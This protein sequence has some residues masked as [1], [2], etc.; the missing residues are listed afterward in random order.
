MRV[1]Q[2]LHSSCAEPFVVAALIA[3]LLATPLSVGLQGLDA[4]DLPLREIVRGAVWET[5]LDTA[6][7]LTA[8]AAAFALFAALFTFAA[9]SPGVARALSLMALIGAGLALALSGHASNA[10]PRIVSRPAV[11]LHAICVAFWVGSLLP[12]VATLRVAPADQS[13]LARFSRFIPL[14][15]ALLVISGAWLAFVQLGRID[16]LWTTGY[17]RVLAAKLT[18]V[19]VLLALAA[20]NRYWLVPRLTAQGAAAARPLRISIMCEFLI[21]LAILALV[22]LWRFTPPPR[23]LAAAAT[24]SIHIHGEKAM[25]QIEI[26]RDGTGQ[27][28]AS[29]QVLDGAF[30][31]LAAKAVTL[32]LANPAAGIEPLRR[33]AARA[34]GEANWRVDDLRVPVAGRWNLRVEILVT[35]FDKVMLDD[36]VTLPRLP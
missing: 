12:L 5:G 32:V 2:V 24:V 9:P 31:P 15:L 21:V 33:E 19:A 36:T 27:A 20:L 6:Y 29:V 34:E 10:A 28:H 11:F 7:G 17:G 25:A 26:E 13:A 8:I 14:P 1:E 18:A 35:D 23:S 16:A 30:R 3:G 4:L 22:A